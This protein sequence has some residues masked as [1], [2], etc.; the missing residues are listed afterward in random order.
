MPVS[1]HSRVVVCFLVMFGF[2][3]N[4]IASSSSA[5]PA[6]VLPVLI[7]AVTSAVNP[8][9]IMVRGG[10]FSPGGLVYIALYDQWG[11]TLHETR[12]VTASTTVYGPSGSQDPAQGFIAG[13]GIGEWFE[14]IRLTVYGPNGSQDPAQGYIAG[15][16]G[17][18]ASTDAS[19]AVYGPNGSQDP[20]QGFVPGTTGAAITSGCDT[21]LMVR[22]FDQATASWSNTLDVDLGC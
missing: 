12:W 21:P 14:Q 22:A 5:Q 3:F 4:G 16:V 18:R 1:V 17:S 6:S 19:E 2:L 11:A 10:N 13:S 15:D 9:T 20:A 8:G 7:N